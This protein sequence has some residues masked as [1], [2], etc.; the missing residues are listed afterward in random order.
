MKTL[1]ESRL[2]ITVSRVYSRTL[3]TGFEQVMENLE[4]HGTYGLSF[5]SLESHG[6]ELL[7]LKVMEN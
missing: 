2:R 6:I 5:P 1:V 4:S 3:A 7:V